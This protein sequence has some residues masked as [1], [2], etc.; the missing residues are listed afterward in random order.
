MIDWIS[1]IA[2][3]ARLAALEVAQIYLCCLHLGMTE[4]PREFE[5][6]TA[7]FQP[8]TRE[9]VAEGMRTHAHP[10]KAS[11]SPNTL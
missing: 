7:I 4:H 11:A 3:C 6:F 2:V 5:N 1:S 9:G 10:L 8:A